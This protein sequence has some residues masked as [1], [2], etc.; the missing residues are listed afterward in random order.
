MMVRTNKCVW[1]K[2]LP[3]MATTRTHNEWL[4]SA[5]VAN[6]YMEAMER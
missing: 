2:N 6:E 5:R 3:K 1:A 4:A